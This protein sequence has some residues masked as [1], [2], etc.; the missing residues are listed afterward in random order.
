MIINKQMRLSGPLQETFLM[1]RESS[2]YGGRRVPREV[3]VHEALEELRNLEAAGEEVDWR[4]VYDAE[5][6]LP[7]V[8]APINT[9]LSIE[10][11]DL[12]QLERLRPAMAEAAGTK[13]CFLPFV[14]GMVLKRRLL[15]APGPGGGRAEPARLPQT[16]EAAKRFV[17]AGI[18]LLVFKMEY[19]QFRRDNRQEAER[20]YEACRRLL[21][22]DGELYKKLSEDTAE[23]IRGVSD[24]Y[25]AEK[26]Q[27]RR[28]K[29]FAT[30]NIIFFG[31][32]LAG[33]MLVLTEIEERDIGEVME[34]LEAYLRQT[35]GE[36]G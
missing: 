28:G 27:P 34:Q 36:A 13:R 26:Y 6:A 19:E 2:L 10:E 3:L 4:T 20:L 12:E 9:T 8:L 33:V 24:Y 17:Q 21:R 5:L 25:N 32:V 14:I 18:D 1:L 22:Q 31:K 15:S 35:A 30:G 29:T 11:K 23:W 7:G 16:M